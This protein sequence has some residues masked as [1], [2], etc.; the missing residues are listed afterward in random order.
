MKT[1]GRAVE[2]AGRTA[3]RAAGRAV[4]AAGRAVRALWLIVALCGLSP[5]LLRYAQR[6]KLQV[7]QSHILYE[8]G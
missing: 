6:G 3:G 7:T 8:L 5:S 4:R 2:A 1:A